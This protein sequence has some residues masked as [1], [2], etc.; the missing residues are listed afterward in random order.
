MSTRILIVDD[1]P[2][3]ER[4]MRQQ[5]RRKIRKGE[6]ECLYA[7]NGEEA[8][9]ALHVQEEID[10]ILCDIN[11]PIMDGLTFI[12]R[13][14][15]MSIFA[16]AIMVS[17]YGNMDNIRKAMNQGAFDFVVKP[18]DFIDLET[19]IQKAMVAVNQHREAVETTQK[20][21]HTKQELSDAEGREAHLLELDKLKSRF[22]TQIS[23][24]FRTPLTVI[25]GMADQI[26]HNPDKWHARGLSLI[27]HNGNTLLDL[28]NQ[29]LDLRK[30]ESGNMTANYIN[31][32][33]IVYLRYI[34]G[35]FETLAE[36]KGIDLS[37]GSEVPQ[38]DMDYDPDKLLRIVSNLLSNAIKFTPEG[39]KVR[40]I[41]RKSD[42]LTVKK[43]NQPS[44]TQ[45]LR[46]S[47]TQT[48]R[49]SDIQTFGH[50]YLL[51]EVS[52]T[53]IG[54]SADKLP[55]IFDSFYQVDDAEP[56]P[57]EGTGIGLALTWELVSLMEGGIE[58][59][60]DLGEG[61]SFQVYLPIKQEAKAPIGGNDW[62]EAP[63]DMAATISKVTTKTLRA[64][65]EVAEELPSLLIIE[66]NPDVSQY[67]VACLEGHYT[68]WTAADGQEGV[69]MAFEHIP[70]LIVSDVMM[71]RKNGIEVCDIL[72][73]DERTSHIPIVL[74]TAKADRD[75]RIEGFT[76]GADAYL[77]K[78]FDQQE[79]LVR[80]DQL[81]AM[82]QRLQQRYLTA[83]IEEAPGD[84]G[85]RMEDAFIQKV[86]STLDQ[87][88]LDTSFG[89]PELCRAIGMS[90][91]QLHQKLKA[92]TGRSTSHYIRFL[93]LSKAQ[94]LLLHSDMNVSE[95]AYTVGF[96]D[97]KYFSR[98]YAQEFGVPPSQVK[99]E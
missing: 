19:T 93:R 51:I 48:F 99:A 62:D 94:D 69:E 57:S 55:Y 80:L 1:E 98:T 33:I 72:K 42:S 23:H 97:P 10:I 12:S 32:D 76:H 25:L 49:H 20:L 82:R 35:S 90:R 68:L 74:L 83:E 46:H 45:T 3:M 73:R 79:L 13:L 5:F 29:L 47:D 67:L 91:S 36:I 77:P 44:A 39:G 65:T 85:T 4:L 89:I 38:V 63:I 92:L 59:T 22:F 7:S 96:S 31:G 2:E 58:V 16:K 24:E 64:L 54:I 30:L 88:L 86:Q 84:E 61:T 56:Q 34:L 43:E 18:I 87:H 21:A 8:L 28:V 50:S 53:G 71:P 9:K 75:S 15:E 66:D 26:K 78:P 81:L 37:F 6:Y 52:D 27:R 70:D 11:M 14:R 60:S 40:L 17:A 41:V 95:V